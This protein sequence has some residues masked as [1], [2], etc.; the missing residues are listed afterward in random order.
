MK[1]GEHVTA[2]GAKRSNLKSMRPGVQTEKNSFNSP[3]SVVALRRIGA[4][5]RP[6]VQTLI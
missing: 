2:L 3:K 4:I 5:L 1:S 6:S